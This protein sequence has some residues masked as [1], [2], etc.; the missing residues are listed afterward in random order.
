MSDLAL[1]DRPKPSRRRFRAIGLTLLLVLLVPMIVW[2]RDR[3]HDYQEFKKELHAY[4]GVII[5]SGKDDV[6]YALGIP[7]SVYG[8]EHWDRSHKWQLRDPIELSV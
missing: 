6:R 5:G 1:E 7:K 2:A 8:P 3:E 4:E